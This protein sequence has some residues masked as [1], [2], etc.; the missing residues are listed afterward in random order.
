M[1]E[2]EQTQSFGLEKVYIPPGQRRIGLALGSGL[3]RGFAHIGV[4]RTLERHGIYPDVVAGCSIG[5]LVGGCY[6]A[7]KLQELEDWGLSLNRLK[8]FSLLDFRIRDAGLIGG[9]RLKAILKKELGD[10]KVEDLPKPFISVATDLVS[11]HEVWLRR[12]DLVEAMQAS[13]AL[14]GV[15]P[16][17]FLDHRYLLD[18]A[19]VNPVPVSVCR[20]MGARMVIAIDLNADSIGK[21]A[22]PGQNYQTIAGF[23]IL[24]E[25]DVPSGWQSWFSGSITRRL[26]SRQPDAP[27]LFGVMFSSLNIIQDRVTRARLAGDPPDVHIKPAIG[28][29]GV[30]EFEKARD[31]IALGEAATEAAM[32]EIRA[33]MDYLIPP[34]LQPKDPLPSS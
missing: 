9:T 7:G 33:A 30:L 19:L 34:A 12:G 3:A 22:K 27:S 5:A 14:P 31:M 29:Y 21:A 11:G 32:P 28:Q 8:V 13:Y 17:V 24:N 16:P 20:A 2:P 25:G 15:F 26:F 6:L 10:L 1:T 23:D 18:G 4:L